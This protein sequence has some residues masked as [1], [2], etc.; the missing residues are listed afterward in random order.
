[1][2]TLKRKADLSVKRSMTLEDGTTI[3]YVPMTVGESSK[4]AKMKGLSDF[5][6]GVHV[7]AAQILVNGQKISYDDLS[8][9][10][11][12][13]EFNKIAEFINPEDEKNV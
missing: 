3:E 10:F 1:M 2:E 4:I 5:D 9:C 7:V 12:I 11:T 6:K 13:E 8:D